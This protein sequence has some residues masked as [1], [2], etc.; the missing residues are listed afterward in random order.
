MAVLGAFLVVVALLTTI[1]LC[2]TN[3]LS[4]KPSI[5]SDGVYEAESFATDTIHVSRHAK[6]A[7]MD[8][9]PEMSF[10]GSSQAQFASPAM[11]RVILK[12]SSG[13]FSQ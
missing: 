13:N 5:E 3:N 4:Q 2:V 12:T 7:A 10:G 11:K 6:M 8:S 9:G 1:D